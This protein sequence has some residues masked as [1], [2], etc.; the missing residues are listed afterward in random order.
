MIA[1]TIQNVL[2]KHVFCSKN[3]NI[4]WTCIGFAMSDYPKKCTE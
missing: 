4:K 2:Q 1:E 3:I